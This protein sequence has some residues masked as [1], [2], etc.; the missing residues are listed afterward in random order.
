MGVTVAGGNGYGSNANQLK[1][2]F[3]LLLTKLV[4]SIYLTE[5]ITEYKNGQ[6]VRRQVKQLQQ[7]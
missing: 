4:V 7:E 3:S 1:N 5:Q 6:Q 2:P